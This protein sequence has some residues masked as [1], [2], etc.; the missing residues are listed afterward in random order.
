[1]QPNHPKDQPTNEEVIQPPAE[2]PEF[3]IA[4]NDPAFVATDIA[5]AVLPLPEFE[6]EPQPPE[7][8]PELVAAPEPA[9]KSE[10]AARLDAFREQ[11]LK[12]R[13]PKIIPPPGKPT[14][15][16]AANTSL[17][18]QAGKKRVDAAREQERL[19]PRPVKDPSA[20]VMTPVHRPPGHVPG[21]GHARA[22]T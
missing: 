13:E 22:K 11:V 5:G 6:P 1:M 21:M 15:R 4:E 7:P 12:N 18:M 9:P 20:G 10:A 19:R 8:E 3:D 14:L 16:Q 17:E 2:H